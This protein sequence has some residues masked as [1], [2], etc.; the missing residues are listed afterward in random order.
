M[1]T[2]KPR[3]SAWMI[4]A[5]LCAPIAALGVINLFLNPDLWPYSLT[6]IAGT[7]LV[8][9]YNLTV[10]LLIDE[11]FVTFKRYGL[12]VWRAPR[13]GAKIEDGLAGDVPF[14]PSLIIRLGPK[15]VGFIAKG[16]F[17][18]TALSALR[19]ALVS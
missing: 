14:L 6:L 18:E 15:R 11:E 9:G 17:G 13:Q 19:Q 8:V 4:L 7:V 16:W 1:E 5:V 12:V 10:R 3:T 2:F